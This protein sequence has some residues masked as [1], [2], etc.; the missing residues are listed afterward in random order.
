MQGESAGRAWIAESD[1]YAHPENVEKL[2]DLMAQLNWAVTKN[3]LDRAYQELKAQGVLLEEPTETEVTVQP[4]T[5]PASV[6]PVVAAPVAAPVVP[7]PTPAA[8][9]GALPAPARVLRPGSSSSTGITPTRR[10]ESVSPTVHIDVLTVEAYNQIP[11]AIAKQRYL[12]EPSFKAA[13]DKLIAE[14]KI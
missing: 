12:R 10:I 13:V 6:V 7:A 2:P 14:G 1:F 8:P 11:A 5:Q 3:N 4:P 9:A